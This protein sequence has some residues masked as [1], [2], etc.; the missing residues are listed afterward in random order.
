MNPTSTPNAGLNA[1]TA[2]LP[3]PPSQGG[4]SR[5][6]APPRPPAPPPSRE[7]KQRA[8]AILEVLAGGRTPA[9]AAQ[10][11]QVSLNR[12]YMLEE[13]ALRGLLAACEPGPK[14]PPPDERRAHAALRQE[15]ER[16]KRACARQQALVRAAQRTIGLA[17]PAPPAKDARKRKTRKPVA[18]AVLAATRLRSEG[19]PAAATG[20]AVAASSAESVSGRGSAGGTATSGQ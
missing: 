20:P 7:A 10:A 15:C 4:T 9:E 17:A 3:A 2:T 13:R 6:G 5:R 1:A 16:W 19:P 14:G 18:R 12:Y 8:A 11:L